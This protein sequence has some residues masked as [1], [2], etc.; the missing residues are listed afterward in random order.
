MVGFL[1]LTL[2]LAVAVPG[3]ELAADEA[4]LATHLARP[5]RKALRLERFADHGLKVLNVAAHPDDEDGSSLTFLGQHHGYATHILYT[6]RGEGGQ[7]EIGDELGDALGVV[8]SAEC[9]AAALGYGARIS[10]LNALDFGFAKT[11][12][13]ALR[14]WDRDALVERTVEELR[15]IRPDLIL[16]HHTPDRGHGHH[17][18]TSLV[19]RAA[20]DRL[21]A[22]GGPT[23]V[24][25]E[26][27]PGPAP[28]A[29]PLDAGL[30]V[31]GLPWTYAGWAHV[32]LRRHRSQGMGL[33]PIPEGPSV[34][35]YRPHAPTV[36]PD[37]AE[38]WRAH[39][40][41][42][43]PAAIGVLV[44]RTRFDGTDARA[45]A[46][47]WRAGHVARP[48]DAPAYLRVG[49]DAEWV[50]LR[51]PASPAVDEVEPVAPDGIQVLDGDR[52][53]SQVRLLLGATHRP[54]LP[55]A[56][57]VR[58]SRTVADS[59]EIGLHFADGTFQTTRL[60]VPPRL[61]AGLLQPWSVEPTRAGD[62]AVLRAR[63]YGEVSGLRFTVDPELPLVTE[64]GAGDPMGPEGR[65]LE[66]RLSRTPTS[67]PVRVAWEH[68]ADRGTVRIP[69][70][71][72]TLPPRPL[73]GF[74][75]GVDRSL[76]RALERMGCRVVALDEKTL[77]TGDLARFP[78]ILL[79]IRAYLVRDDLRAANPR[80]LAY[81]REGGHLVV[82]YQ[83][84]FEWN[85]APGPWAPFPLRLGRG[86]VVDETAPILAAHPGH[87]FWHFPHRLGGL[88][89]D[90]WVQERG[91]YFP[92]TWDPAY[93]SLVRTGDPGEEPRDGSILVARVGAGAYTYTS[94]VWYRQLRAG[95][96]GA[97]RA[98]LNLLFWPYAEAD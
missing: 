4:T 67:G 56:R 68:P 28:D 21:A 37:R 78:V 83:K 61:P 98:F 77:T 93:T 39:P 96:G 64:W 8:R 14:R 32:A 26:R 10:F 85:D 84:T 41:P 5:G 89:W 47:R 94:L 71:A 66:V 60:A 15:R 43:S 86:R 79:D 58:G 30:D 90:G 57:F 74:V 42:W 3:A 36:D 25:L 12:D 87:P 33:G 72:V 16:T 24:L 88:D 69:T 63:W 1:P 82:Q 7:N 50:T 38:A 53:A 48:G 13:E 31:P 91:L 17:R 73:V 6:T 54:T 29:V 40:Y 44:D 95:V 45:Q 51:L 55:A 81:A 75:E 92:Q 97:T 80:L 70:I 46:A 34:K 59:V 2:L 76:G 23:P 52:D 22:D 65:D 35:W 9:Q 27:Q 19:L 62:P 18:A 20:C 11:A 49:G